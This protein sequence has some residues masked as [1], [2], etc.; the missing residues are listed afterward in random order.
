MNK[1]IFIENIIIFILLPAI[2]L[3]IFLKSVLP[4]SNVKKAIMFLKTARIDIK[5]FGKENNAVKVTQIRK[6]NAR[7]WNPEWFKND[8]GQGIQVEIVDNHATFLIKC[9]NDGKLLIRLQGIDYRDNDKRLPIWIDYTECLV[10][11]KSVLNEN[12]TIVWHDKN[13]KYEI[14]VKNNEEIKLELRWKNHSYSNDEINEYIDSVLRKFLITEKEKKRLI[15]II[16][17]DH[18]I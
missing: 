15:K 10:N 18:N 12:P 9:I 5:N 14:E 3:S 17:K 1:N 4:E 7:I 6:N 8:K 16:S 13:F 2:L 11:G